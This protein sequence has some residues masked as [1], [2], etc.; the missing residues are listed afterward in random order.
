MT[1][2]SRSTT[3]SPVT[4]GLHRSVAAESE[5][6]LCLGVNRIEKCILLSWSDRVNV[7]VERGEWIEALAL[8]LD[9]YE[10]RASTRERGVLARVP[11]VLLVF[12]INVPT[13]KSHAT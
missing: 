13:V 12:K 2:D 8:A 9:F 5:A 3:S 11:Q 6:L 10:V 4:C 1:T 7:L